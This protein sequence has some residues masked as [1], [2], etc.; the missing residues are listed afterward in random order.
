MVLLCFHGHI[1]RM[2]TMF[3][4]LSP[5]IIKLLPYFSNCCVELN[6]KT[7]VRQEFT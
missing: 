3:Y 5:F 4:H 6:P 1:Q 2:N 7:I